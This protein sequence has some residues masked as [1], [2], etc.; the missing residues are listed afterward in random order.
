MFR[1]CKRQGNGFQNS[2]CSNEA[3]EIKVKR[4]PFDRQ[5]GSTETGRR[6]EKQFLLSHHWSKTKKKKI[7]KWKNDA[8][9]LSGISPIN[10]ASSRRNFPSKLRENYLAKK[11]KERRIPGYFNFFSG[12]LTQASI[13]TEGPMFG[14]V[15]TKHRQHLINCIVYVFSHT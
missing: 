6:K 12:N 13:R 3:S 1:R 4:K 5:P 8:S 15:E 9:E 10:N 2:D 11:E 14:D 7:K